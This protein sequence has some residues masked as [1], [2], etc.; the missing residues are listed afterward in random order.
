VHAIAATHR[1][2]NLQPAPIRYNLA[3][4]EWTP[5]ARTALESMPAFAR[6]DLY[7]VFNL[8]TQ[9]AG[10]QSISGDDVHEYLVR[11]FNWVPRPLP[12]RVLISSQGPFSFA[13]ANHPASDGGFSRAAIEHSMRGNNPTF[14]FSFPPH[15]RVF[16]DGWRAGWEFI[17]ADRAA[18]VHNVRRKFERFT[19][20]TTSG[21]GAANLPLGR[22]GVR[23]PIDIFVSDGPLSPLWRILVLALIAAG[24]VCGIARRLNVSLWLLII[25]YKLAVTLVFYGYARQGASIAPAFFVFIA[26]ANDTL[27][28][29]LDRLRPRLMRRHA[30]IGTLTCI[31]LLVGDV[32]F[33]RRPQRERIVGDTAARPE[34]GPGAFQAF[35]RIEIR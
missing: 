19:D 10:R 15:N 32:V 34:F 16:T 22:S 26:I 31:I 9:T 24:V 33:A 20:G 13:L 28:I 4:I 29:P 35:N 23:A 2:N 11:T 27:L 3:P 17:T 5:S 6:N 25:V 8:V 12:E 30:I 21:F 14:A 18:T 7:A 1:F